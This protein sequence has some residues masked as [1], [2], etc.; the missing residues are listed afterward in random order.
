MADRFEIPRLRAADALVREDR[1]PANAFIQF[2]DKSCRKIEGV[3]TNIQSL[4]AAIEA[5]NI[6]QDETDATIIG[7]LNGTIPFDALNV[8][9]NILAEDG[10]LADGV[11]TTPTIATDAVTQ[12]TAAFTAGS[13]SISDGDPA[14]TT[15]QT[16]TVT[17][18]AIESIILDGVMSYTG[19]SL[20]LASG[21]QIDL[22]LYRGSTQL[23]PVNRIVSVGNGSGAHLLPGGTS[24]I[25]FV[26][27]PGAGTHTYTLR[28]RA[29]SLGTGFLTNVSQRF[30]SALGTKR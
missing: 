8:G 20:P 24:A 10:A 13:V 30:L 5:V 23:S 17:T 11:V 3:I 16:I 9:G 27:A 14:E 4:I 12:T 15:I 22:Y 26:E 2:W 7:V 19:A 1:R 28:V 18:N 21:A 25:K 29:Y 6:R